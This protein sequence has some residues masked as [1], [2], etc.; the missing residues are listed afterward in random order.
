MRRTILFLLALVIAVYLGLQLQSDPGYLLVTHGHW[1]VEMPL[2]FGLLSIIIVYVVVTLIM[3]L[4]GKTFSLRQ[5][6]N[7][8][9]EQRRQQMQ[10]QYSSRGLLEL[11]N[12]HWPQAEKWLVKAIK[13]GAPALIHYLADVR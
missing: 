8:W 1:S 13:S 12:G 11:A 3:K 4:F 10:Q 5:R 6:I 2:W 9:R 7:N